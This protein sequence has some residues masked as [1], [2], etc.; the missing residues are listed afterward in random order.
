[1]IAGYSSSHSFKHADCVG[2]V[3]GYGKLF[4]EQCVFGR[5]RVIGCTEQGNIELYGQSLYEPAL[6][7]KA[8]QKPAIKVNSVTFAM[9]PCP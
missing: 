9:Q 2:K 5:R 7:I 4:A 1:M 6:G 8:S 3:N